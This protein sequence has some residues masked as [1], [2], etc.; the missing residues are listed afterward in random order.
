[1]TTRSRALLLWCLLALLP[2]AA[3]AATNNYNINDHS[4]FSNAVLTD[5]TLSG[6]VNVPSGTANAML[7]LN[8]SRNLAAY[9][10]SNACSNAFARSLSAAGVLTCAA[11][12]NADLAGSIAASKLIGSDI[13]TVGTITSGTWQGSIL[14]PA[15]GGTG[16]NLAVS[17]GILHF[18]AGTASLFSTSGSGSVVAL[19]TSPALVT[20]SL[21][22]A[23][24]TSINGTAIPAATTLATAGAVGTSGVT[25]STSRLLGRTTASS[26]AVEEI[27]VG[28]GLSLASGSLTATSAAS[29]PRSYLAGL[30]LANNATDAT[31]DIDV[32]VGAVRDSTNATDIVLASAL[33]KQLDGAWTVGTNQGCRD[34]GAIANGTWHIWVIKRSDTSV[35][36]IL[37]SLSASAPTMPTNYDY[38]RRIGAVVRVAAA[39]LPFSQLGDEFLLKTP[40]AD[41]NN[42]ADHT[43]AVTG[44][45]ASLPTGVQLTAILSGLVNDNGTGPQTGTY[46]SALDQTDV[47]ASSTAAPG[48]QLRGIN[49]A[50]YISSSTFR[51]RTNASAQIRYRANNA[52]IDTIIISHGWVD[53]RGRD[54]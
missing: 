33:T 36:D 38:R 13:A 34:T 11:V 2:P 31:N 35:V 15:Y 49:A 51:V 23:T 53:R 27:T 10:G 21:G 18:T 50:V 32:A 46:I 17:T 24:A 30:T 1:M 16:V 40:V 47:P 45:L 3:S 54:D 20:P 4:A 5:P 12:T 37:C 22:V 43:T 29:M 48:I 25:M 52:A 8:S 42:T 9:A 41:I 7:L 19:A 26:G 28:A 14:G 39:I 6:T 44:T